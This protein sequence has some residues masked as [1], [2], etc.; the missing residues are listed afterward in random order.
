M[1]LSACSHIEDQREHRVPAQSP[2]VSTSEI[3]HNAISHHMELKG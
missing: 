1:V 3:H 2:S